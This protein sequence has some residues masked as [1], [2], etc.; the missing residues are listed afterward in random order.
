MFETNKSKEKKTISGYKLKL[1]ESI[2]FLCALFVIENWY[3]TFLKNNKLCKH[4]EKPVHTLRVSNSMFFLISD[5]SIGF[6]S[7]DGEPCKAC[8]EG[9]YGRKCISI[10]TCKVNERYLVQLSHTSNCYSKR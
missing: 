5:C 1:R 8:P 10:C 2:T 7:V 3:N 9:R 4:I 6:V